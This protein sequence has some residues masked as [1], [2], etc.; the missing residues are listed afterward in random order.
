MMCDFT[1][2][3]PTGNRNVSFSLCVKWMEKQTVYPTEWII[4]D[5]GEEKTDIPDFHFVRY[6]KRFNRQNGHTLCAQ[7]CQILPLIK[8]DKV[9]VMEDDDWYQCSYFERTCGLLDK[10]DIVG[11]MNNQYYFL[12]DREYV[13]HPNTK[14]SSFCSTAFRRSMFDEIMKYASANEGPY[15]DLRI[16]RMTT[17]K[18][19]LYSPG[20]PLV[21]GMKQMPGRIGVTYKS[22]KDGR[23]SVRSL[24]KDCDFQYMR[25]V[26]G[27]DSKYYEEMSCS[28][29]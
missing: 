8:T 4:M 17:K 27:E 24:I 21:I 7:I 26:M 13:I 11:I 23:L 19:Y 18:K 9:I 20:S 2:I 22:N 5:D 25:K 6:F 10:A 3:T 12:R 15:L 28:L 29:Q 16:W 14:H 1:V